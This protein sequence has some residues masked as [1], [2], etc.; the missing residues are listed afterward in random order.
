MKQY[1]VDSVTKLYSVPFSSLKVN[2]GLKK[3][4]NTA[5]TDISNRAIRYTQGFCYEHYTP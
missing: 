2:M 4:H 1:P 3:H 5:T